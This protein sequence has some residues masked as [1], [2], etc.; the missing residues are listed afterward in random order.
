[1]EAKRLKADDTLEQL[2]K[3]GEASAYEALQLYRSKCNRMKQKG[4][5]LSALGVAAK[6]SKQLLSNGYENAGAELTTVFTELLLESQLDI[7]P[8][9]RNMINEIDASYQSLPLKP[10]SVKTVSGTKPPTSNRL[11]FLKQIVLSS[12]KY[13]P[14]EYGDPM[15]HC[16]LASCMWNLSPQ[17]HR[18]AVYHFAVG[19]APHQLWNQVLYVQHISQSIISY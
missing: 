10:M 1:M 18:K 15:F 8:D 6:G 4:E 5:F 13:G 17:H 16:Q 9:I 11:E 19:E 3:G 2:I 14:R 12:A 7:S